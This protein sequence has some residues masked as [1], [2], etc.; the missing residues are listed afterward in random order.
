MTK[1]IT[2]N[3]IAREAGVSSQTVS[4]VLN[5]R[6][7]VSAETRNRIQ[8]IIDR[9]GYQPNE[10]ARSLSAKRTRMIGVIV[11]SLDRYGPRM[12][13]LELDKQVHAAGYRLLPYITHDFDPLEA[14]RYLRELLAHQPDGVIWAVMELPDHEQL[15][16]QHILK[17]SVPLVTIETPI[18]GVPKPAFMDQVE[19]SSTL[20]THLIEQGYSNIGIIT[21]RQVPIT[22]RGSLREVGWKK[23]ML[24]AGLPAEN[25]QVVEGC[26]TSESG[27]KAMAKLIKQYP[28]VDAVF[29]CNDQ[30][31]LGVISYAYQQDIKVPEQ[32]G[33]VGFDDIP[34]AANFTPPLTTVR[35]PF[36]EFSAITVRVLVE[37]IE[38]QIMGKPYTPPETVTLYADFIIR[39]SSIIEKEKKYAEK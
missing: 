27:E 23:A 33:V 1:K 35:Q 4:R 20:V 25:R 38:A 8:A 37:M 16:R 29:A 13:F 22:K 30:M 36:E 31:A 34:E 11:G 28:E 14:D 2:L 7:D 21:G 3:D 9:M 10:I 39:E 32:L 18:P 26:W 19:A 12:I 17:S 15:F 5:N 6:P 24:E